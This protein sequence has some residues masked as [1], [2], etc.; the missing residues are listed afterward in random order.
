MSQHGAGMST[1]HILP[2]DMPYLK[3]IPGVNNKVLYSLA[4]GGGGG[5]GF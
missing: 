3:Y 2:P 1:T 5:S 4:R